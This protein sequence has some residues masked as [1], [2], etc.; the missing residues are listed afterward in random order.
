MGGALTRQLLGISTRQATQTEPVNLNDVVERL[1]AFLR[2][3]I[4]ADIEVV[5]TLDPGVGPVWLD[6]VQ[7]EQMVLNLALNAR[8]AMPDGGRLLIATHAEDGETPQVRFEVSD[9]GLGIPE[10]VLPRIFDPFFTTKSQGTGL[11]LVTVAEI[12][13]SAHGR[14]EVE[15]AP[16]SGTTF[17][18]RLPE[19]QA[20]S[21]ASETEQPRTAKP[22][23]EPRCTIL[24]AEDDPRVR[25][26]LSRILE[27]AGHEVLAAADGRA[28][29]ERARSWDGVLD[30]VISDVMMPEMKGPDLVAAVREDRPGLPAV[31]ISGLANVSL[32]PGFAHGPTELI[33]KPISPSAL[34]DA[35]ARL[36]GGERS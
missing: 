21:Q 35:V 25:A 32:E 36:A 10:D 7:A 24:L 6:P 23:E 20:L 28:A 18:I 17:R 8:D 33:T 34:R 31:L 29:L 12:V 1:T 5:R 4:P 27:Q 2:R 19:G 9:T 22:G 11:G 13:R 3:V 16:A 26:L 15:S 14:V 30:L